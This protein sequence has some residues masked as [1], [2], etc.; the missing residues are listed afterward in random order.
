[1]RV[2]LTVTEGERDCVAE[3]QPLPDSAW[4]A[5]GADEA[6][7]QSE[8][9]SV[10][11]ILLLRVGHAVGEGDAVPPP[12][13]EEPVALLHAETERLTVEAVDTEALFVTVSDP[14]PLPVE[15]GEGVTEPV[16]EEQPE[17]EAHA[18]PLFVR[19][20]VA[21]L[22]VVGDAER[23]TVGQAV[24][25][26]ESVTVPEEL[27]V[28]L[29]PPEG[30]IVTVPQALMLGVTVPL[31]LRAVERDTVRVTDCVPLLHT[32]TDG[33]CVVEGE[34]EPLWEDDGL[35]EVDTVTLGEAVR[36][37]LT[38]GLRVPAAAPPEEAVWLRLPVLH[39]DPVPLRL[40][41]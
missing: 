21:H 35:P 15:L 3:T 34:P 30:V 17:T 19:E 13:E 4:L 7:A 16:T 10:T 27:R 28:A 11:E 23:E 1:M 33:E 18:V 14:L 22:V 37:A 39:T 9:V 25:L 29:R 38:E 12:I 2:R 5:L 6:E 40:P 26:L 32:L 20:A 24:R 41:D 36:E 31:T 8:G